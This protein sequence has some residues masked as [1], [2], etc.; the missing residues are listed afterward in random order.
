[1]NKKDNNHDYEIINLL[2]KDIFG[3]IYK[4]LNKS[5]NKCYI[6]KKIAIP[7]LEIP[8]INKDKL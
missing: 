8:K 7:F 3:Y 2:E 5:D 4:V 1:M 6:L